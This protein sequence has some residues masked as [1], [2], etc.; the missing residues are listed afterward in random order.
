MRPRGLRLVQRLAVMFAVAVGIVGLGVSPA[1]ALRIDFGVAPVPEGP[2][3]SLTVGGVTITGLQQNGTF[4][5]DV[6]RNGKGIGNAA[7]ANA[8]QSG[9]T[10]ILDFG[11][12]IVLEGFS[13][14]FT[15]LGAF[16]D[17]FTATLDSSAVSLAATNGPLQ[18]LPPDNED[19]GATGRW[20]TFD[21][22]GTPTGSMLEFTGGAN[23][24]FRVKDVTIV[25]EPMTGLLMGLGLAGLAL[26]RRQSC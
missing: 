19:S 7:G 15:D 26:L 3:A 13:L 24:S 11:G 4:A 10:V 2:S 14:F 5:A 23:S 1:A 20:F 18:F 22:A 8:I 9:E 16:P 12:T 6:Q 25:P 21:V 17:P